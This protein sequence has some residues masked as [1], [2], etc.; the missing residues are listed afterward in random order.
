VD[1]FRDSRLD[2][3][4]QWPWDQAV[5]PTVDSTRDG[6]LRLHTGTAGLAVAARPTLSGSYV[7]SAVLDVASVTGGARAGLAA[8][9]N[10]DNLLAITV[11]RSKN[12]S[13]S[14]S[15]DTLKVAVWRTQKGEQATLTTDSIEAGDLLHLQL[16]ATDRTRFRFAVSTDGRQWKTVATGAEGDYLPPWDLSVRIA[17]IVAGP[18]ASAAFGTYRL[19]SVSP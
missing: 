15:E 6:W 18:N 12:S 14:A 4:W 9:G 8:F 11:E 3:A 17:M 10:R 1:E 2:P 19:H 16:Q 5:Q 13:G 7:A